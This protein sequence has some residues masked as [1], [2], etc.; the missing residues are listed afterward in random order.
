M[1]AVGRSAFTDLSVVTLGEITRGTAA[2]QKSDPRSAA[3]FY[4]WLQQIRRD[5]QRR[6]LPISEDVAIEWGRISVIRTRGV[7][8][9]LIAATAIHDL[10]VVT[11][12]AA[13]FQDLQI[14]VLN[15]WDAY[16][17]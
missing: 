17:S 13:D 12:N 8:D 2:K 16:G 14:A 15:P 6:V 11:P 10:I 9:G 4:E 1:V 5:F 7:A 3:R